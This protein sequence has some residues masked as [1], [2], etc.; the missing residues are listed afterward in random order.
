MITIEEAIE[1]C[2]DVA[3]GEGGECE[4]CKREHLQLAGWLKELL[5][6]KEFFKANN[7]EVMYDDE[8]VVKGVAP[9]DT[10]IFDEE[11]TYPNCTVQILRNSLTGEESVGWFRNDVDETVF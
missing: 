1:H 7:L 8:G 11:E 9:V 5:A 6:V 2:Y 10:N 4:E 3:V